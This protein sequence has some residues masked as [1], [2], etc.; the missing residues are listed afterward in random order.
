MNQATYPTLQQYSRPAAASNY[1]NPESLQLAEYHRR[2]I[3]VSVIMLDLYTRQ[4]KYLFDY[5]KS[6]WLRETLFSSSIS[7]ITNHPAY[8]GIIALGEDALPFIIDD[9]KKTDAHW[10]YAL[11][12]ITAK[13]PIKAEHRGNVKL[14][15]ADWLNL[16]R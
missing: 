11:E 3:G 12:K 14:M 4:I 15:K 5:Y 16:F 9:L 1:A 13:N 6:I 7:E 8:H 2:S 10:F